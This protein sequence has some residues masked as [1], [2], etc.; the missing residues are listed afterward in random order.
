ML[1]RNTLLFFNILYFN[2]LIFLGEYNV[3]TKYFGQPVWN[4]GVKAWDPSKVLVGAIP[5]GRVS[6]E[7]SFNGNLLD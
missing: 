7:N 2:I 6:H 3:V 4:C 1:I 5:L